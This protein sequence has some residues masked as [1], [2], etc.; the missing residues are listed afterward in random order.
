MEFKTTTGGDTTLILDD[1]ER[2]AIR[3]TISGTGISAD[4][5]MELVSMAQRQNPL[6]D[7]QGVLAAAFPSVLN[8][9]VVPEQAKPSATR[10]ARTQLVKTIRT[11]GRDLDTRIANAQSM[12]VEAMLVSAKVGLVQALAIL[13]A[14]DEIGARLDQMLAKEKKR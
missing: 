8:A 4:R 11:Q 3:K 14:S 6:A 13:Q 2:E 7:F 9:A 10:E 12:Q 5:A 1:A